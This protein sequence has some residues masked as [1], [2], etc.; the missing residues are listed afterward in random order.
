[1]NNATRKTAFVRTLDYFRTADLDEA[2]ALFVTAGDIIGQR[3][4][5]ALPEPTKRGRPKGAKNKTR[6]I[7]QETAETTIGATA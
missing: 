5:A 4:L 6:A 2:N 7:T 1:M 3:T